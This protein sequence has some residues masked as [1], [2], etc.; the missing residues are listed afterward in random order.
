MDRIRYD[1]LF[2]LDQIT[3]A[4]REKIQRRLGFDNIFPQKEPGSHSGRYVYPCSEATV[5]AAAKVYGLDAQLLGV[6]FSVMNYTCAVWGHT[7]YQEVLKTAPPLPPR[8]PSP[9]PPRIPSPLPLPAPSRHPTTSLPT[10]YREVV[11]MS[12]PPPPPGIR[13]PTT[14]LATNYREVVLMSAP[15]PPPGI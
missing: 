10:N 8:I 6:N 9:L 14:S 3:L 13:H 11:L 7:N 2:D 12:A 5:A 4:Q 1:M 15:P